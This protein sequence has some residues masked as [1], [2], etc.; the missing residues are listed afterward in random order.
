MTTHKLTLADRLADHR[1]ALKLRIRHNRHVI[2]ADAWLVRHGILDDWRAPGTHGDE[3]RFADA[4]RAYLH[5]TDEAD[6]LRLADRAITLERYLSQSQVRRIRRRL[7][8][9]TSWADWRIGQDVG[10]IVRMAARL[11]LIPAAIGLAIG[12]VVIAATKIL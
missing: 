7:D 2:N 4:Y 9:R 1:L 6:S 5:A 10:F 3:Q 8:G 11:I 12:A